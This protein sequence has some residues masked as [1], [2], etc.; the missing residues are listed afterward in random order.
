MGDN[1]DQS[2]H[3]RFCGYVHMDNIKGTGASSCI[4]PGKGRAPTPNGFVGTASAQ[5]LIKRLMQ[6]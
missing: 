1:R 3:S 4:G 6:Y 5:L 2:L